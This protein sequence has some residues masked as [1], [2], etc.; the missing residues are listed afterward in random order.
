MTGIQPV[1]TKPGTYVLN[2]T[3]ALA[4]VSVPAAMFF[5][6]KFT[7]VCRVHLPVATAHDNL[8]WGS[9]IQWRISVGDDSPARVE[10]P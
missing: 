3:S 4:S 6:R 10:V 5:S 2:I 8:C 1:L 9:G 7:G